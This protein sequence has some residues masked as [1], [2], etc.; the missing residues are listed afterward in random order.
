[1]RWVLAAVLGGLAIG[2]GASA[3]AAAPTTPQDWR[4][5]AEQ[6]LTAVHDILRDN[7]PAAFT[8]RDSANFR[9]WLDVGLSEARAG[10]PKVVDVRSYL[11][12]MRGYVAGFRDSHI[13]WGPTPEADAPTR[14]LAWAGFIL[15]RRGDGYEVVYR[16]PDAA[17]VPP[18]HARLVSCDGL[19]AETFARSH[20]RYDGDFSLASGRYYGAAR[21]MQ[22]R[23][24]PFVPRA[25]RCTF[26]LGQTTTNYEIGWREIDAAQQDALNAVLAS[27]HAK[28][29]LAPWPQR[30]FWLTI[31]TME[32]NQDWNAFFAAVQ[33]KLTDLREARA[34]VIDLRGNGG[35][36][37][38]YAYQLAKLLWGEALVDQRAPD[39]G[40]TVWRVSKLNREYW[41]DLTQTTAKD[42]QV[43][44]DSRASMRDIL[45]RYDEALAQG[46]TT[47]EISEDASAKPKAAPPNPMR[48]RVILLTDEACSSACLDLMDLFTA[49]PRTVQVGNVTSADTIFMELTAVPKLPSG[50]SAFY[51]GHKVWIRRPRGSNQPYAP[52]IK[53]TWAGERKDEA[54]L[55]AWL[56]TVAS[57]K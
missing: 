3:Q 27:P 4:A 33:A 19:E 12:V 13:Q 42:P 15:G 22:D 23:G 10:L 30:G 17:D 8:D 57:E 39:L 7:S 40:P 56:A 46:K 53:Y 36:D 51:F 47:F 49:M 5:A 44:A 43:S 11:A 14:S 31:P 45:K 48:G 52:A 6:D 21:L 50:L 16:S 37:S 38:G 25:K 41:A 35:G 9:S 32:S 20:D 24:N 18:L 2:A 1:M 55:R 28:L 54:G 29:G 34:L 26:H